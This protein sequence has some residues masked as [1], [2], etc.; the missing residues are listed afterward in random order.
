MIRKPIFIVG[1]P[2]SGTTLCAAIISRHSEISCGPETQFFNKISNKRLR[3]SIFDPN[4]PEK[5]VKSIV[6][7]T[8]AGQKVHKLFDLSEH[9]ITNFLNQRIPSIRSMLECLTIPYMIRQG[10]SRWAEKTPNHIIYT[11]TIRREFPEAKI[12]RMIRDFRDSAISMKKLPW[13]SKS[14]IANAYRIDEWFRISHKFFQKDPHSITIRYEDMVSD[15]HSCLRNV[16]DFIEAD[17][18]I[19]MTIPKNSG[20]VCS[21]NEPWKTDVLKPVSTDRINI[22]KNE[23][24]E[25]MQ[26]TLT[27]VC[28]RWLSYFGYESQNKQV[29]SLSL[30]PFNQNAIEKHE[31]LFIYSASRNIRIV[32]PIG[33]LSDKLLLL[34]PYLNG[35]LNRTLTIMT[36]IILIAILR[37]IIGQKVLYLKDGKREGIDIFTALTQK[38]LRLLGFEYNIFLS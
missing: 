9:E 10:K 20:S 28:N 13:A 6:S 25:P 34:I 33:L 5:A 12:I 32:K 38:C 29:L 22:W 30:Y 3:E 18:E 31:D 16:C 7:L 35:K 23:L 21:P 26:S 14:P 11:A 17:F 19:G 15:P 1:A 2:R 27:L 4:W 37:R 8:L 24:A 36:K